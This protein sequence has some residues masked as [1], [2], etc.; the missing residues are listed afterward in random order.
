VE[1]YTDGRPPVGHASDTWPDGDSVL[2]DAIRRHDQASEAVDIAADPRE[3]D[4]LMGDLASARAVIIG[5]A[6]STLE[7]VRG[8]MRVL[9]ELCGL[10]DADG[11]LPGRIVHRLVDSILHDVED[12]AEDEAK[13]RHA[14]LWA[15]IRATAARALSSR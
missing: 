15:A 13:H 14:A 10:E 8:K 12:L 3:I 5:T 1:Q 6:A 2:A 11:P 4:R 9:E 7:G